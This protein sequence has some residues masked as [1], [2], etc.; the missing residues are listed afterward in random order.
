VNEKG[1]KYFACLAKTFDMEGMK[2]DQQGIQ[3]RA[4]SSR[5]VQ[6]R[7]EDGAKE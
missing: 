7:R 2:E 6:R 3:E 1:V 4:E 5:P